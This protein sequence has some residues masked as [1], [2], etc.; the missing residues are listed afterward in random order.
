MILARFTIDTKV[1]GL[2]RNPEENNRFIH[3]PK[4]LHKLTKKVVIQE[5]TSS[6]NNELQE[7]TVVNGSLHSRSP[8]EDL[9]ITAGQRLDGN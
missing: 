7:Y 1:S 3:D 4:N 2:P 5:V 8:E 9:C 6:K